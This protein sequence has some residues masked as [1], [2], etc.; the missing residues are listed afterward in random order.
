MYR[1]LD[2]ISIFSAEFIDH[3]AVTAA[4]KKR[5][6]KAKAPGEHTSPS[7]VPR[8]PTL[9]ARLSKAFFEP[10][11]PDSETSPSPRPAGKQAGGKSPTKSSN[12]TPVKS[13]VSSTLQRSAISPLLPSFSPEPVLPERPSS[14]GEFNFSGSEREAHIKNLAKEVGVKFMQSWSSLK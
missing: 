9:A 7:P 8:R 14:S 12:G 6:E 3:F 13:K 4:V 1:L 10:L 5:A 11:T 2:H